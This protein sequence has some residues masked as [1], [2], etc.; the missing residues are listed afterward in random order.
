MPIQTATPEQVEQ[1]VLG[2]KRTVDRQ[3]ATIEH[4]ARQLQDARAWAALWKRA[5]RGYRANYLWGKKRL[6]EALAENERQAAEIERLRGLLKA[7]EW[8]RDENLPEWDQWCPW[9]KNERCEGHL[10]D[11]PGLEAIA[12][13]EPAHD[14]R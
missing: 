3:A 1:C 10:P 9:C 6:A 13:G 4:Q 2:L 12:L 5:A 14:P 8:V 7:V 11:C